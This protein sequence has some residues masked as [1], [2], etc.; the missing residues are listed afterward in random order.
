MTRLRLQ[1]LNLRQLLTLT[2]IPLMLVSAAA[3]GLVSVWFSSQEVASHHIRLGEQLTETLARHSDLALL[4]ESPGSV[5]ETLT[6]LM[7]NPLVLDMH[8]TSKTGKIIAERHSK[9][10]FTESFLS[11][12]NNPAGS[13]LTQFV[14]TESAWLF[15]R[16]V[17]TTT[18]PDASAQPELALLD[19]PV[20]ET[21]DSVQLALSKDALLK[22]QRKIFYSTLF[23]AMGL[24]LILILILLKILRRVSRPLEAL[25]DTMHNARHGVQDQPAQLHGPLEIQ[26]IGQTY[27]ELMQTLY[28][29]ELELRELNLGLEARIAARTQALEAANK[30]LEA[31]S[32]SVSHDLRGPFARHRRLQPGLAGRLR[33][34]AGQFRAGLSEPHPQGRKP[35]GRTDRRHADALARHALRNAAR[36]GGHE[37]VGESGRRGVARTI[38]KS[39]CFLFDTSQ[40]ACPRRPQTAAYRDRKSAR[41]RLEIHRPDRLR[42]SQIQPGKREWRAGLQHR[43]QWRRLRHALRRQTLWRV[44]A[45]ARQGV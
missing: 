37:R 10:A 27:N 40:Y 13:G 12:R 23:S 44:S 29:R 25:A 9:T 3:V 39:R 41:Q 16:E 38:T 15:S 5:E 7:A 22:A 4:Y 43:G 1:N 42:R 24:S 28:Q 36:R 19:T 45:P 32:Y 31:F 8:V 11:K 21:L 17:R 35:H 30:E 6:S 26:E 14:E 20:S 33:P 2:T 34:T 18:V